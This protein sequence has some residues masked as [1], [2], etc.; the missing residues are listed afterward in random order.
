MSV[1]DGECLVVVQAW[2]RFATLHAHEEARAEFVRMNVDKIDFYGSLNR[3]GDSY[4]GIVDMEI[5]ERVQ[6][7]AEVRIAPSQFPAKWTLRE[8]GGDGKTKR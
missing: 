7:G 8:K 2:D 5:W 3:R 1:I 6:D 4:V